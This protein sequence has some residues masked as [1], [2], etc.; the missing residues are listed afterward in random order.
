[1]GESNVT[2]KNEKVHQKKK[3]KKDREKKNG[4]KSSD[5]EEGVSALERKG[6]K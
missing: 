4:R 5:C 3:G 6:K 1:M 2:V